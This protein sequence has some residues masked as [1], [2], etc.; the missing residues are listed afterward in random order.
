MTDEQQLPPPGPS[1]YQPG[2]NEGI[3][4]FSV[5]AKRDGVELDL[6][7]VFPSPRPTAL[8]VQ[9][10]AE[11]WT[12]VTAMTV[13]KG[14]GVVPPVAAPRPTAPDPAAS[15]R[16]PSGGAALV[17][18]PAHFPAPFAPT[19]APSVPSLEQMRAGALGGR[20]QQTHSQPAGPTPAQR[21]AQINDQNMGDNKPF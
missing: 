12:A 1:G 5:I 3:E 17:N 9:A 16:P 6:T 15:V 19:P 4:S 7:Y 20:P 10:I 13:P 8:A 11:L 18:V 21:I 14:A 2:L